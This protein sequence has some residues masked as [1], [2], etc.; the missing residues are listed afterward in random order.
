MK[1]E[2]INHRLASFNNDHFH[3]FGFELKDMDFPA[4]FGDTKFICMGGSRYRARDFIEKSADALGYKP[5]PGLD[6]APIGTDERYTLYKAGP[7]VS[8]SHGIGMPSMSILLNEVSKMMYYAGERSAKVLDDLTMIR[9]GTCGGLGIEP[10]TV[11]VSKEA[12]NAEMQAI[13]AP[14]I[15]GA[16]KYFPT[17]LY[18]KL[19]KKISRIKTDANIV[20]GKTIATDDFYEG[21][22]R[23][24]GFY[25]P[26]YTEDE[27]KLYWEMAKLQ[28]AKNLEME[29]I[30]FA[31]FTYRGR[32]RSAIV[33][34]T[35][36]NRF[37]GDQ[38]E[39]TEE[40]LESYSDNVHR[41]I[42]ELMK[43]ELGANGSKM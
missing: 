12:V 18:K 10:G 27:V 30:Q 36:V 11:V 3:H 29:A 28:E 16:T 32:I 20:L 33:N 6:F 7:V 35:L 14:L 38:I 1:A 15:C 42:L 25:E 31:M 17:L 24:D 5:A 21:Q 39:A 9:M 43:D 23:F 8:V 22:L 4:I 34:A 2:S 40:E 19:A 41:V 37:N 26:P 13:F